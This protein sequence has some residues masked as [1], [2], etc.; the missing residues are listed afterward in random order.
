MMQPGV[1]PFSDGLD[2]ALTTMSTPA[3]PR[4][5]RCLFVSG[6]VSP[7][8]RRFVQFWHSLPRRTLRPWLAAAISLNFF[9]VLTLC[10]TFLCGPML[11][12]RLV[13]P[14]PTPRR[15][16]CRQP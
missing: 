8:T 7:A 13:T 15:F 5:N 2:E 9:T 16:L 11:T 10:V 1:T 4:T 6:D 14:A 3:G 12:A